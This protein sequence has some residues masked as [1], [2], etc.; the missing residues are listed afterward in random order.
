MRNLSGSAF[1]ASGLKLSG[2]RNAPG[3]LGAGCW[4]YLSQRHVL[5][6][7]QWGSDTASG[8]AIIAAGGLV[9]VQVVVLVGLAMSVA[10]TPWGI[11]LGGSLGIAR[12]V[13]WIAR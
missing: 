8:F 10:A 11:A 7:L 2:H 4:K 6:V 13:S 5:H 3:P 1:P 12:G 9:K